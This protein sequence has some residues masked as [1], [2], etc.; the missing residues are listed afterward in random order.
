MLLVPVGSRIGRAIRHRG[1]RGSIACGI[2]SWGH[3][4][5]ATPRP[6]AAGSMGSIGMMERR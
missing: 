3:A 5:L 6:D 2:T 1:T 4:S